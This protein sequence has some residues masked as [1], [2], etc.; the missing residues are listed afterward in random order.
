MK[1]IIFILSFIIIFSGCSQPEKPVVS[2]IT[3]LEEPT[4]DEPIS[5]KPEEKTIFTSAGF[6]LSDVNGMDFP[7]DKVFQS[8][9]ETGGSLY[10]VPEYS[11]DC[12]TKNDDV[13]IGPATLY[14]KT[15]A[16]KIYELAYLS[17]YDHQDPRL[18]FVRLTRSFYSLCT[19]DE[20]MFFNLDTLMKIEFS[21]D[22]QETGHR[23]HGF[24]C[25]SYDEETE[26]YLL[27]FSVSDYEH[28]NPNETAPFHRIWY[29]ESAKLCFQ[30]FASNGSHLDTTETN[31][32]L[33]FRNALS[34]CTPNNFSG[35]EIEFFRKGGDYMVDESYYHYNFDTKKLV[36]LPAKDL[37]I[38]EDFT[39][40][41]SGWQ[42]NEATGLYETDYSLLEHGTEASVLKLYAKQDFQTSD[43]MNYDYK[44]PYSVLMDAKNKTLEVRYGRAV[45]SLN[46]KN[47]HAEYSYDYSGLTK[48]NAFAESPDGKY[49]LYCIGNT[50][51]GDEYVSIAAKNTETGEFT[52]LG[53]HLFWSYLQ[54]VSSDY[55]LFFRTLDEIRYVDIQTGESGTLINYETMSGE[56]LREAY[57]IK[58]ELVIIASIVDLFDDPKFDIAYEPIKLLLYDF[59]GNFINVIHTDIIPNYSGKAYGAYLNDMLLN[60]DGTLT[61]YDFY[62]IKNP[63]GTVTQN[64]ESITINYL[65]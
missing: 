17:V 53:E 24:N 46:F 31:I 43:E 57:D 40:I 61:I 16:G 5:E 25:V 55:R 30:R 65:E 39:V 56:L 12:V 21:L 52:Y 10:L 4:A 32:P 36:S 13:R 37:F 34:P 7:E 44:H 15:S 2:D 9:P 33:N 64:T 35:S 26:T 48:E 47:E 42:Y 54:A 45:H 50:G 41:R 20:I 59:N 23:Y 29:D 6:Y 19:P 62:G 11:G 58:N 14:Y 38:A 18:P 22:F 60:G 28:D 51:R 63:D 8:V 49:E 27:I 1:I 3:V